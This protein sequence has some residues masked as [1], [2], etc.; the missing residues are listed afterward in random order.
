MKRF[1]I[2]L[3]SVF[4]L[5][6]CNIGSPNIVT[7]VD[8]WSVDDTNGDG[9]KN[10]LYYEYTIKNAGNARAFDVRVSVY[11]VYQN[12]RE[13]IDSWFGQVWEYHSV[14][15]SGYYEVGA[16]DVLDVIIKRE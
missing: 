3:I 11:V 1:F 15:I 16:K 9:I 2:V 10:E 5:S 7:S 13:L 4:A 8:T 14:S 12:S 6:M